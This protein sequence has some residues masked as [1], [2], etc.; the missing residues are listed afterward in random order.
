LEDI[1]QHDNQIYIR[2][3][4][5]LADQ[6]TRVMKQGELFAIYDVY[7][8]IK[9][10]GTGA[11]GLFNSATRYLSQFEL[12]VGD[13]YPL[14]LSSN[15]NL[16]NTL[17]TIDLSNPDFKDD[18]TGELI[19]R[20][21]FHIFRNKFLSHEASYERI[22]IINFNHSPQRLELMFQYSADFV[23]MFEIR[24][25]NRKERGM[26][27]PATTTPDS[28]TFGYEGLDKKSRFSKIHF[29]PAPVK[30]TEKQAFFDF[31]CYPGERITLFITTMCGENQTELPKVENY[32]DAFSKIEGVS[33]KNLTEGCT[34][35]SSSERFNAWIMRSRADVMLLATQT[36]SGIYPYAGIPWFNTIFGR[37]G[38]ITALEYLWVYPELAKGVLTYLSKY[39]S[40]EDSP[41]QDAEPGKILHE[42][43]K[44]EM[45]DTGEVPFKTYYGSVDS[46]P[47]FV[48]LAGAYFQWTG[49]Q[50]LIEELWPSIEK[51]LHWIDKFGDVDGDG[52]VEYIKRSPNGLVNQGWKDSGDSIS[53]ANGELA[54]GP[55]ALCEVQGYVYDAKVQS[56]KMARILGKA[57]L[58][59]KLA[60]E[61]EDLRKKFHEKYWNEEL[62][63][64]AL[65]LDGDKNPCLV[66]SSNA[67]QCLF[68]GIAYP[69]IAKRVA[70]RLMAKDINSGWGIRTLS[71]EEERYNPMSYHN[72]SIWPHD[73]ALIAEG[74]SRYGLKKEVTELTDSF[75][76][77]CTYMDLYRLPELFCGFSRRTGEGPTLYPVA[78]S[79]QAWAA[80]TPFL[81]LKASLGMHIDSQENKIYFN[82]PVLP[83]FL[84]ELHIKNLKTQK[85]SVDLSFRRHGEEVS[86]YVE[87]RDG[88]VEVVV[89]K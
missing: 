69:E 58:A 81:L 8:D 49:D 25:I 17:F 66:R 13:R 35:V 47:L 79:P 77:V 55:I 53:H 80:A 50:K 54:T 63:M 9:P 51:A 52:F 12:R 74:F 42:F 44:G 36:S 41:K 87:R 19:H 37:D 85:G 7:G 26:L 23:D 60:S 76:D 24:G 72:G 15:I 57:S 83:P 62:G 67:G 5:T 64:F 65:A 28:V 18:K 14:F 31:N 82:Y 56:S 68:S 20:G 29:S 48:C 75:F 78:C 38:I 10:V 46:T 27:K 6:R 16:E 88:G 22:Q 30:I 2:A 21:T 33:H 43:R 3:S 86:V 71:Q 32:H 34:I 61:A 45:V 59:D 73:N 40:Q 39:Q 89:V 11:Q 4:S 70:E 1:I 84:T